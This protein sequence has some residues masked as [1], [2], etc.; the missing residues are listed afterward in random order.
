MTTLI[1]NLEAAQR[2]ENWTP[3]EERSEQIFTLFE[4]ACPTCGSDAEITDVGGTP[5][6]HKHQQFTSKHAKS[7]WVIMDVPDQGGVE[8]KC[9]NGHNHYASYSYG[10]WW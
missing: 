6:F 9:E 8:F 1:V 7:V 10:G 5:E 4:G 3:I 2:G